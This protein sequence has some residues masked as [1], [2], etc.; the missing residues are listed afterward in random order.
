MGRSTQGL[1]I[2]VHLAAAEGQDRRLLELAYQLE[3]A[4]PW[5]HL[6]HAG[7]RA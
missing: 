7:Q 5:Q 6:Y 1:P 3:A 4:Q 2:G